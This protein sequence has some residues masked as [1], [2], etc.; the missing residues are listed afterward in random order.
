MDEGIF[1]S[2]TIRQL[3]ELIKKRDIT[4]TELTSF[5]L[6]RIEKYQ[7]MTN[8]FVA[9][10]TDLSLKQAN[11]ADEQIVGGKYLG[12]L[13]GIPFAVKDNYLTKIYPTTACSKILE[14]NTSTKNAPTVD[15]LLDQGA[16]LIGKTNMH[17]WAYG[18]TNKNS[19]YGATSNPWN[20]KHI[21]G[22]SSGGSSAAVSARLVPFALG[23]DTGGSV[24]IP[25]AGC[26][27]NGLKPTYG[28]INKSGVL[29]LS[30]SLDTVGPMTNTAQD[31]SIMLHALSNKRMFSNSE[32]ASKKIDNSTSHKNLL[33]GLTIGVPEGDY[34]QCSKD[35]ANC[36]ENIQN[37]FNNFGVKLKKIPLGGLKIG[38]NSWKI[39]LHS[40]A[41]A[42]HKKYM[43]TMLDK[44]SSEVRCQLEVG[45]TLSAVSYLKA[46]QHRVIFTKFYQ[47]CMKNNELDLMLMPTLPITAP[48]IG[49]EMVSF[50]EKNI[51]AQNS[52]TYFAW[53]A[54]FTG[55]PAVSI[56]CGFGNNGLPIG[57]MFMGDLYSDYKLLSVVEAYQKLSEWHNKTPP[58]FN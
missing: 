12:P 5:C 38:F 17:E 39:I 26:G 47:D 6:N 43:S 19:L 37:E 34:F 21:T 44:Y 13:H 1:N 25:S 46:Q 27:I 15:R 31:L 29:P 23:S 58:G 56:P 32:S 55:F 4:C 3:S 8:S 22:G 36:Y 54:N 14:N 49:E 48:T 7:K 16:I 30:W 40:E 50:G 18:A 35:V 10:D 20:T 24:R 42:F 41:A 9:Y 2:F 11:F 57:M 51:S 45:R 52:M 33:K 53:I 28:V